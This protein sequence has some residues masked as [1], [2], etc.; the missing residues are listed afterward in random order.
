[1][2][3][4]AGAFGMNKSTILGRDFILKTMFEYTMTALLNKQIIAKQ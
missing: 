2:K 1:M 4:A 3:F